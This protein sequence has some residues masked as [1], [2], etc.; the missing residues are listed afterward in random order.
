MTKQYLREATL[1]WRRDAAVPDRLLPWAGVS[2]KHL[3][4]EPPGANVLRIHLKA[5]ALHEWDL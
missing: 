5:G 2:P 4:D 1:C 3:V